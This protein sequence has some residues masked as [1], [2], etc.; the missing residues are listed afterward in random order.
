M[1]APQPPQQPYPGQGGQPQADPQS[2]AADPTPSPAQ[3]LPTTTHTPHA[4]TTQVISSALGASAGQSAQPANPEATQVVQPGGAAPAAPAPDATQVVP[5]G[6]QPPVTPQY[7]PPS[8][9]QPQPA[10]QQPTGP[11]AQ[12]QQQWGQQPQAQQPGQQQWGQQPQQQPGYPQTGGQPQQQWGQQ[13]GTGPQPQQQWGQAQAQPGQQQGW[14]QQ[15]PQQG[16]GQ[17]Q[18]GWGQPQ[19]GYGQ[20]YGQAAGGG[21]TLP[22]AMWVSIGAGGLGLLLNIFSL[23]TV[24]GIPSRYVTGMVWVSVVVGFLVAIG[25]I[26]LGFLGGSQGAN[27]ARITISVLAGLG[28]LGGL[29]G[30]A[31]GGILSILPLL[32]WIAVLVL[33]WLPSTTAGMKLKQ[34]QRPQPGMYGQ[35]QPPYGG[36]G[37]GYPGY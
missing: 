37:G 9:A 4:D 13:P 20:P 6:Q 23:I 25:V 22:A 27:W 31:V 15:Q 21:N 30:V 10:P 8:F 19:Q 12:P 14:G 32:L 1:S 5:P 34:A 29:S 16:Y 17:P 24:L 36:G 3:G 33:W 18:Q 26:V 11:Q 2:G 35:Q 7:A 28:V